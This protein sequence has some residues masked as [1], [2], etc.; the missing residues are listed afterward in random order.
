MLKNHPGIPCCTSK[1]FARTLRRAK[2]P[3]QGGP[4]PRR[5]SGGNCSQP[6]IMVLVFPSSCIRPLGRRLWRRWFISATS[7]KY[8]ENRS[9]ML[10]VHISIFNL[11]P[12]KSPDCCNNA[13]KDNPGGFINLHSAVNGVRSV[14][15][16]NERSETDKV[17]SQI[18]CI[19]VKCTTT[20]I[21]PPVVPVPHP[22][23]AG[24]VRLQQNARYDG[25][26]IYF[27]VLLMPH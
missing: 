2:A 6:Q 17:L 10:E 1:P 15:V 21:S 7:M 12:R 26:D 25:D 20:V 24:T 9:G 5:T 23:S 4:G 18:H 19:H 3:P 13:C 22:A 11:S 16:R 14:V 27:P 8:T